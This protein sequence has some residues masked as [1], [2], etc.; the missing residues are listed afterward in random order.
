VEQL[1]GDATDPALLEGEAFDLVYSNSVIEHVGG[2]SQRQKFAD[3]VARLAPRFWIQ[4]PYRGFPIEPHWLFPGLHYLPLASRLAIARRWPLG[5]I[6]NYGGDRQKVL[7]EL[8][9]VE[10]LSSTEWRHLFPTADIRYERIAG[11][12]KSLIAMKAI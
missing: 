5:Y 9:S 3:N 7:N 1:F 12:P 6:D 8:L 4:T 11:L 2:A 10:L